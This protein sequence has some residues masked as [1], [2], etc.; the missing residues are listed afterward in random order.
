MVLGVAPEKGDRAHWPQYARH[1]HA[2]EVPLTLCDHE[3]DFRM[4]SVTAALTTVRRA[5][6]R[7]AHNKQQKPMLVGKTLDGVGRSPR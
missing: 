5:A 1:R 2:R 4:R 3:A 7:P 6:V